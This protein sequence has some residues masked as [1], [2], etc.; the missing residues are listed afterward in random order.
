MKMLLSFVLICTIS[1]AYAIYFD[2]TGPCSE[3]PVHHGVFKTDLSDN[4]GRITVDFLEHNKIPYIGGIEGF[5]SIIETP[6]GLESM[7]VISDTKMR[8]YGWCFSVNGV[9]PDVMAHK[10]YLTSQNDYVSWFYAYSTYDSGVWLD[11]CVPAYENPSPQFC[12]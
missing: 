8:A 10:T 3:K 2:I 12:K 6:V 5:N 7:E 9:V 1:P 4:L 11:Y